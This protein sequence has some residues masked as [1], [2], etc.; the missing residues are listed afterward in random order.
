MPNQ[1]IW[2]VRIHLVSIVCSAP[3]TGNSRFSMKLLSLWLMVSSAYLTSIGLL[4]GFNGTVFCYGQTGSGKT[5]TMEVSILLT[6]LKMVLMGV[7]RVLTST[8]KN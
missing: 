6:S 5:F 1:V 8:T 2:Q 3:I 4:N 7:I